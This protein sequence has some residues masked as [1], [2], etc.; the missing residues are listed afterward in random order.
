MKREQNMRSWRNWQTRTVQVRVG[1]RGGSNPLDRTR[2]KQSALAGC[3]FYV[4]HRIRDSNPKG[5]RREV[6]QS[7]GLTSRRWC[8]PPEEGGAA[9]RTTKWTQNPLDR[10][11]K[12]EQVHACSIFLLRYEC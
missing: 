12:I 9:R 5:H 8:K 7:G 1:N 6:R 11:K 3:F 10:T 4:G 2:K